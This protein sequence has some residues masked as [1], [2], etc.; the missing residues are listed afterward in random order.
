MEGA[1]LIIE[2]VNICILVN[3]NFNTNVKVITTDKNDT[4]HKYGIHQFIP[5][6]YMF[7]LIR[8]IF[9]HEN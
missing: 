2:M 3:E 9:R 8:T 1:I 7:L 5:L 4:A 6:S